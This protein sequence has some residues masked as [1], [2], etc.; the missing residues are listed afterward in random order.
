[1]L[2]VTPAVTSLRLAYAG[3]PQVLAKSLPDKSRTVDPG[4][5]GRSVRRSKQFGFQY[6]LNGFHAVEYTQQS[7]QQSN[8]VVIR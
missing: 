7:A 5:L 2:Q 3:A 1:M 6:Q 8:T 4:S